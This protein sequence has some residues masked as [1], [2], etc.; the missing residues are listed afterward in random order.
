MSALPSPASPGPE[1]HQRRHSH[2]TARKWYLDF[3]ELCR[4]L[5]GLPTITA[6]VLEFLEFSPL[7]VRTGTVI[8]LLI[9]IALRFFPNLHPWTVLP[10]VLSAIFAVIFILFIVPFR[11]HK[12]SNLLAM[13]WLNWEQS[14]ERSAGS[15]NEGD[16]ACLAKVLV[17]VIDDR[18]RPVE[19]S[20]LT[21]QASDVV[22]GELLLA[23]YKAQSLLNKRLSISKQF[24][25]SG[26]SEPIGQSDPAAARVREY[27]VP[28][29]SVSDKSKHVWFWEL[30]ADKIV[31]GKRLLD[32]KL[33]DVL[34]SEPTANHGEFKK[35]WTWWV[36]RQTQPI[37]SR[38]VL[39]RFTQLDPE[40]E[41]GCLGR[42]EATRVFMSNLAEVEA[43]TLD[44]ASRNS[45][46]VIPA[47][48]D[49]KSR[50]L[51]WV[52]APEQETQAVRATWGNVL[53]N[54]GA[55]VTDEACTASAQH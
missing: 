4:A 50:L 12:E 32:H 30:D 26:F 43:M 7:V 36:S 46:Y 29:V 24:V 17:P 14:L 25:G 6:M 19:D 38:P 11:A 37:D 9:A 53:A 3:L 51:V 18:P 49:Y 55:W 34:L 52:Y 45:G 21:R 8:A 23:N 15:C 40:K 48:E 22:A 35:N 47:K 42:K 39:V 2:R 27:L 54:F 28:N 44:E 20:Q 1:P 33:L 10:L 16:A 13:S 31:D 5:V 41:S